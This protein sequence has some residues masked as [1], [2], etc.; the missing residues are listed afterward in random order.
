MVF[1][2]SGKHSAR[3]TCDMLDLQKL[4]YAIISARLLGYASALDKKEDAELVYILS[5]AAALLEN[6]WVD[7]QREAQRK[8]KEDND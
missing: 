8:Q 5:K 3:Y 7:Y 6:V 4:Q 1:S 2:G